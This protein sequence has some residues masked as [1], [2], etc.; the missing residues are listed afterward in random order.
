MALEVR[1]KPTKRPTGATKPCN[2]DPVFQAASTPAGFGITIVEQRQRVD[3]FVAASNDL[4]IKIA[5]SDDSVVPDTVPL[6]DA[7]A[8]VADVAS[9]PS[10]EPSLSAEEAAYAAELDAACKAALV[11]LDSVFAQMHVA[12][13]NWVMLAS[14]AAWLKQLVPDFTLE[15]FGFLT[16]KG[17][18]DAIDELETRD[19]NG[20]PEVR[21]RPYAL[22][23]IG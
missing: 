9:L 1:V 8:D 10:I 11:V 20:W 17:L 18:I 21:R 6:S 19:D 13:G 4:P 5:L 14:L 16:L 12:Q 7:G 23:A 2:V 3:D 15:Q 22:Q